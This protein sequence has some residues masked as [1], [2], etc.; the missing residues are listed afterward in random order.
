MKKLFLIS[1]AVLLPAI[2]SAAGFDRDL[3]FGL[4]HDVDVELLQKFLS[5]QH[6]YEGPLSGNFLALTR[7]AVSKFQV[8][9]RIAPSSGYF[10]P[11]TRARAS[12]L[13]ALRVWHTDTIAALTLQ[14]QTLQSQ[15]KALTDQ[16]A[17][18]SST[19]LVLPPP[20]E[21]AVPLFTKNPQIA[22]AGFV[23][24]PLFG[25]QYPYRMKF[26][27]ATDAV[28]TPNES[29]SCTPAL[30]SDGTAVL[31]QARYFPE[32][33]TA[34][35][36]SATVQNQAG[37]GATESVSFVAPSWIS[38]AGSATSSFP[39]IVVTPLKLGEISVYNG[40]TS[41]ILF[42][43]FQTTISDAMDSTFNRNHKVYFLLRDG[44]RAEDPLISQTDF[45]FV[46]SPPAVGQP[47][48]V[49]VIIPFPVKLAPG[50]KKIMSLWVEQFQ[51]VRS[52]TLEIV[53]TNIVTTGLNRIIGSFDIVLTKAPG[54]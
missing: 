14:I 23:S 42:S 12:Q 4:R 51:F 1:A 3:S 25:G 45:T 31:R 28:G 9:E 30:K 11:K 48:V 15:L 41:D 26:D 18:A 36:C 5:G 10:G 22:E 37:K 54:L 49:P 7:E 17:Q 52:G 43:N 47:Y 33:G 8:R 38:V 2:A 32:S 35:S 40:S 13:A 46:A 39:D 53:S 27:W 50:E 44:L 16:Q 29:F 6:L 34:Y 19:P 20:P 21:A 24:N